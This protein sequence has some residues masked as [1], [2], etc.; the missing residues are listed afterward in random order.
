MSEVKYQFYTFISQAKVFFPDH[1][2]YDT[3]EMG[4]ILPLPEQFYSLPFL[5]YKMRLRGKDSLVSFI[6]F[7]FFCKEMCNMTI[8]SVCCQSVCLLPKANS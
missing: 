5:A 7:F 2:S 6:F 1:H 3:V 4:E 8:I